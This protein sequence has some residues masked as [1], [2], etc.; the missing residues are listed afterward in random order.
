MMFAFPDD[1]NWAFIRDPHSPVQFTNCTAPAII[2]FLPLEPLARELPFL[3]K[4]TETKPGLHRACELRVSGQDHSPACYR[5][6]DIVQPHPDRRHRPQ[7]NGY[8]KVD[9]EPGIDR[10]QVYGALRVDDQPP[11]PLRRRQ[12]GVSE[13]YDAAAVRHRR[14]VQVAP[15]IPHQQLHVEML[16][17]QV[18]F[19]PALA[20]DSE[21]LDNWSQFAPGLCQA[22]FEYPGIGGEL[23]RHDPGA[24]K[25]FEAL[26]EERRRHSWNAA[27][28]FIEARRTGNQFAE[29]NHGPART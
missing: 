13:F 10:T 16:K 2:L 27:T 9:I 26:R 15:H 17:R 28:K 21:S 4:W 19:D 29:Q 11:A 18:R 5:S 6:T 1:Q 12:L 14:G 20:P 22:I 25:V 23:P 24:L 8:V 7:I 3:R